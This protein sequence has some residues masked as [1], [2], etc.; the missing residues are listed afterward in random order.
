MKCRLVVRPLA[1]RDLDEQ[2]RYI[3]SDN[4]DA[5]LRFLDA[6][7]EAFE[8]LQSFPEIGKTRKFKHPQLEDIRSWPIPGFEKHVI[9]YRAVMEK[10]EVFRVI[11][12]AGTWPVSSAPKIYRES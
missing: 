11:H 5:A 3:A 9:F 7:E 1:K 12:A 8:R 6:S 2:A 10:V 4:V